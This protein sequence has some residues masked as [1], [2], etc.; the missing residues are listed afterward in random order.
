MMSGNRNSHVFAEDSHLSFKERL[1]DFL[2]FSRIIIGMAILSLS[3]IG[4][5]AYIVAVILVIIGSI[6][7][8]FDGKIARH[9][10]GENREGKLGKYDPEID[11]FLVF[12][13]LA[14]FS[15]SE[16]VLPQILGLG[17]IALA[18]I[19]IVASRRKPQVLLSFEIP[20]I[21][22]LIAIAA[23]YDF[24]L[25]LLLVLPALCAGVFVNHRRIR[26]LL[27]DYFPKIFSRLV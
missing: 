12:C 14:Y 1:G 2:T 8:V 10:L 24:K 13:T 22:A 16:I 20:S 18:L 6:T 3:L 25:F 7:D 21:L 15:F 27:F 17:W 23:L 5:D 26:Y 9:Y 11:T 4:R 19:I